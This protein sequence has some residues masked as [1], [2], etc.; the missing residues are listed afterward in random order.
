MQYAGVSSSAS[1][2]SRNAS[3]ESQPWRS[4]ASRSAG[5]VAERDSGYSARISCTSS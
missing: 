2:T 3:G 1:A 5:S 4:C